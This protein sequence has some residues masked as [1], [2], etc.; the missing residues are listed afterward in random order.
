[1]QL[2]AG[3]KEAQ[4]CAWCYWG[5]IF[6]L[7]LPPLVILFTAGRSSRVI[8]HHAQQALILVISFLVALVPVS[9]LT[10][11]LG[12][13]VLTLS[14]LFY[15]LILGIRTYEGESVEI[16]WSLRWISNPKD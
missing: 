15:L 5:S 6:L 16:P 3:S 11:L 7:F 1:M 2:T 14:M 12:G 9:L 4:Y 8:A 13:L 10:M